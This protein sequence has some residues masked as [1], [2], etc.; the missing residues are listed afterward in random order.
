MTSTQQKKLFLHAV[1]PGG[2]YILT[3]LAMFFLDAAISAE[4]LA[5]ECGQ[6]L[7]T[8]QKHLNTLHALGIV[9]EDG[10]GRWLLTTETARQLP[11][12]APE[13][14]PPQL[15]ET[16]QINDQPGGG[17]VQ[18]ALAQVE[19]E[20]RSEEQNDPGETD[21]DTQ[22]QGIPA[23]KIFFAEE[24]EEEEDSI[25]ESDPP[26]PPHSRDKKFFFSSEDEAIHAY[27]EG[28]GIHNAANLSAIPGITLEHARAAVINA[29][30][31]CISTGAPYTP[32]LAAYRIGRTNLDKPPPK[33]RGRENGHPLTC[34]CA[35]DVCRRS[36]YAGGRFS[37]E[38]R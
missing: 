23:K 13:L 17:D 18:P 36:R 4:R 7:A 22:T 37:E 38:T 19:V 21:T 34:N 11:M 29:K 10:P 14:A 28:E 3:T 2:W 1:G 20:H 35:E 16:R 32:G 33:L 8:V 27:L 5:A 30:A 6:A 31:D 26:P 12:F 25:L 9:F 24:E 15:L